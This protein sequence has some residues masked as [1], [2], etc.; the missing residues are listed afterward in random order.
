MEKLFDYSITPNE[1][2]S[3]G[4]MFVNHEK[5]KRS[6]HLSHALVSYREGYVMSI[7]SNCSGTRNKWFPGHNGFG[8]LE[9]KVSKDYGNT[10][11]E[12]K[13]LPYS[14]YALINEPFTISCEKAVSPVNAP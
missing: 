4:I 5:N 10:W 7:Y 13:I 6:G 8:W 3:K 12:E 1:I 9:Y 2:P 14:Y 11:S